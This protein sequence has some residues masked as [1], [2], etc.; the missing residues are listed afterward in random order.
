MNKDYHAASNPAG[1]GANRSSNQQNSRRLS[2][3][4]LALALALGCTVMSP[5][6]HAYVAGEGA[7]QGNQGNTVI[8]DHAQGAE[9]CWSNTQKDCSTVI[10][11]EASAAGYGSVVI[12]DGAVGTSNQAVVIGAGAS[13]DYSATAIGHGAHASGTATAIGADVQATG[14]RSVAIGNGARSA[15]EEATAFGVSSDAAAAFSFAMGSDA[16]VHGSAAFGMALGAFSS[17]TENASNAVALGARSEASRANTVSLGSS[18]LQRQIA[19]MA[20][21]VENTDAV[22]VGQLRPVVM[23]FGGGASI[24][25]VTGA[26]T[27]PAYRIQGGTQTDVG[28]ALYALDGGL[29][30]AQTNIT[31][32]MNGL[33]DGS[34]LTGTVMYDRNGDGTA[35]YDN[36]TLGGAGSKPV[37]LTNVA[38][39]VSQYDA[40]NYGQLSSVQER[41][42]NQ[43]N[44][45]GGTITDSLPSAKNP[46][47]DG[48]PH[49]NATLPSG[50]N[51]G[52]G[53]GNLAGG[54]GATT[55]GN[56]NTA[57][58]TA[59]TVT[60]NG[61]TALGSGAR[62]TADNA[63]AVGVGAVAD[64]ENT[65]SVGAI[66]NE[67]QI[68]NVAAG[69]ADTDAVN[70]GQMQASVAQGTQQANTYTDAQVTQAKGYTDLRFNQAQQAIDTV[71]R[72]AYAGVA[73]AMAMPNLTPSGP[74]RTV[75]AAGAASYMGGSAFAAG[76]SHRSRDGHWL[77]N[78]A[79]SVTS[80]G[81]VGLRS[82][83]GYEF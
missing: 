31:D 1:S 58:G 44:N 74:G 51:A 66:G 78:A 25:P 48:T 67:R 68:T 72:N 33:N 29:R 70:V 46:Y 22:N 36:I 4:A 41:L 10:G 5:T 38:N 7:V 21:G 82:Q 61:G 45:L 35:N 27:G 76:V 54:D 20:A 28:S 71:A 6:V 19:N 11:R 12:G 18:T 56:M 69:K 13:A 34:K 79:M 16:S 15:G 59:S 37:L 50:A 57:I 52:N 53:N 80:T 39:G 65:V 81:N 62:A 63:T 9:E 43:I 30:T 64:R 3:M 75:V 73:A 77:G 55:L 8:G 17:V 2:P 14:R 40:V 83:V 42:Q 23:A 60:A 47:V 26:V 24:D 49:D 32:I